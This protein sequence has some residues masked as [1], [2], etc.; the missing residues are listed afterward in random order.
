MKK[1]LIKVIGVLLIV[2]VVFGGLFL[3]RNLGKSK[4][5]VSQDTAMKQLDKMVA[6]IAPTSSTPTKASIDFSAESQ[7][8]EVPDLTDESIVVRAITH[9]YVEI[10]ASPEKAGKGTDGWLVEMANEYNAKN[11]DRSVQIRNLTSGLVVDY[12]RS[13]KYTPEG[14]SPSNMMWA[15]MLKSYN[16]PIK[17]IDDSMVKNTACIIIENKK[18]KEFTDKYG[19]LDLRSIVEA[20]AAGEF[21]VGYTNPFV[22]ST[23]LNF[24]VSTLQRYDS[25]HPLSATAV[26]GF[27]EFQTNVPFVAYN[28]IQMRDAAAKG[29]L[30]CFV[31][32]AQTY[33][34]DSSL[35]RGYTAIPFGYRHD[36]P[37][38][39][40]GELT[41]DDI[42]ILEDFAEF[43]ESADAEK[44]AREYGFNSDPT[45]SYEY[46]DLDG[47]TLI[48]AQNIYKEAKDV[49]KPIIGVFVCDISGS[50]NG[51]PLHEVK[52]SL[53]NSIQYINT[54][55]YIGLVSY[56]DGV[57]IEVPINKFDLNQ[58]ALFKGGV[59]GLTAG[60]GT[61][62]YDGVLV[63]AKL[64]EDKI[65]EVPDAKPVIFVLSDGDTNAGYTFDKTKTV[66]EGLTIPVYTICYNFNGNESLKQ[67]AGINEAAFINA[68]TDDVVYQLKN[69]LN[70][71]M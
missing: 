7:I 61:A 4:K 45:Y 10:A 18:Y 33:N 5:A 62:T 46:D 68:S 36:N 34:N 53:V 19:S 14:Y 32:E 31:M 40:I 66:M 3:T 47:N 42:E 69:L 23:G 71:S 57:N 70:A 63:A 39:G 2:C 28:T 30:D 27:T 35:V 11:T 16:I 41:P 8:I 26:D 21:T 9:N 49:G 60:G 48:Q 51:A 52:S 29:T 20:T 43:C 37:L 6:D 67:L 15:D 55:N 59:I 13:G 64:I 50:M 1:N 24:L 25:Q 56:S 44:L 65:A 12:I 22:S 58:Q 54:E 17:V 38:V